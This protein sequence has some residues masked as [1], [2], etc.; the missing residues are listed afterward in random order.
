MDKEGARD[1]RAS[2]IQ[3]LVFR[4]RAIEVT[5]KKIETLRKASCKKD[6]HNEQGDWAL[7]MADSMGY[8]RALRDFIIMLDDKSEN[9]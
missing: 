7:R 4:K 5:N 9:K 8:E 2:Y 3:A 6:L 1:V